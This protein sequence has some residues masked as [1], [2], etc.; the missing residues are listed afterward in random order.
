MKNCLRF[1]IILVTGLQFS[2]TAH[3][4]QE[5]G[6]GGGIGEK[7]ITFAAKRIGDNRY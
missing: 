7:N 6:N 1:L 3:A 4:G 2:V 5:V